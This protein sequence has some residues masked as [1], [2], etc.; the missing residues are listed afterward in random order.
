MFR[1][2]TRFQSLLRPIIAGLPRLFDFF[3]SWACSRPPGKRTH[4]QAEKP[5]NPRKPRHYWPEAALH[6][7]QTPK[8]LGPRQGGSTLCRLPG[9]FECRAAVC[10]LQCF[11]VSHGSNPCSGQ[12]LQAFPGFSIFLSHGRARG[13]P[14]G[15]PTYKPKKQKI[16]AGPV[17]IDPKPPRTPSK[18][19]NFGL[20]LFSPMKSP[21]WRPAK[22]AAIPILGAA[23]F[24]AVLSRQSLP[25]ASAAASHSASAGCFAA[26]ARKASS[27]RKSSSP[28]GSFTVAVRGRSQPN[29]S[30]K[31]SAST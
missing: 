5:K 13:L 18:L 12:S 7:V 8:L 6:P 11:G 17:I 23:F 20:L 15:V 25:T 16:S 27:G 19:R 14:T 29:V 28:P 3:I 10:L 22:K 24:L 31:G 21:R 26:C 1:S 2:F 30:K 4:L 9:Q